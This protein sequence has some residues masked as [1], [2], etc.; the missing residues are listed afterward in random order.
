MQKTVRSKARL[1]GRCLWECPCQSNEGFGTLGFKSE[2]C[3]H[4]GDARQWRLEEYRRSRLPSS[5]THRYQW[6]HGN[7]G[8]EGLSVPIS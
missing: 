3:E 2:S 5:N 4:N 7:K 6:S 8:K 1:G